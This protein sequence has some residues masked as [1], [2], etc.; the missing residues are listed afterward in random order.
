[1]FRGLKGIDVEEVI[2]EAALEAV[3]RTYTACFSECCYHVV[4]GVHMDLLL[5]PCASFIQCLYVW[6]ARGFTFTPA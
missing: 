5:H 1:M 4:Y 6:E 3:A 2:I